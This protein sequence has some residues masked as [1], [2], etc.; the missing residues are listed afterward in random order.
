[1]IAEMNRVGVIVD[2]AHS[3]WRTSLEAAKASKRPMVASH[4]ACAALNNHIRSKPDEVMRA[5]A[6]SG[7]YIGICSV[8][9]FLGRSADLN[10]M[11]DHLD[12][13]I[14]TLGAEH[15][16]IG[17]DL[18]YASRTDTVEWPKIPRR[19]R[20]RTPFEYFWPPGALAGESKRSPSLAWINWPMFTVGMVQRGHSDA[21][22][23]KVL[24]GNVLRVA[25]AA[26]PPR[27]A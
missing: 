4:S 19:P 26:L 27:L 3:G 2:V 15:V 18:V 17:T 14:K 21:D 20:A 12:Y 1:V 24:G 23:Q 10:A 8:P 25:R 13:A 11:L 7:G 22:I 9:S 6:D 16:A 5:I